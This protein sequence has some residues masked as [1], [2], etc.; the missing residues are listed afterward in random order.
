METGKKRGLRE[1]RHVIVVHVPAKWTR[2]ML[3]GMDKT[4]DARAA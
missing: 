4:C 1:E 3:P 2:R